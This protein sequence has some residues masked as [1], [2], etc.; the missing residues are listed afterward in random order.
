MT[1]FCAWEMFWGI[2]FIKQ[3]AYTKRED[4]E[5]SNNR[6]VGQEELKCGEQTLKH[7]KLVRNQEI[8]RRFSPTR[9]LK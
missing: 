3:N 8:L 4:Q 6:L 2:F 7:R 1:T 9:F 5:L